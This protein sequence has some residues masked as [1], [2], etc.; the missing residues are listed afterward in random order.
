MRHCVHLK[1]QDL[2]SII[3]SKRVIEITFYRVG[4]KTLYAGL[5]ALCTAFMLSWKNGYLDRLQLSY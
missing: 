5:P 2:A 4:I 1:L 3:R